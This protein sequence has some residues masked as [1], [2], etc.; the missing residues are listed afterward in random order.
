MFI[1]TTLFIF[2]SIAGMTFAKK[3]PKFPHIH[4]FIPRGAL[5]IV[6]MV[7]V[8]F[9]FANWVQGLFSNPQTFLK[10]SFVVLTFPG[11]FFAILGWIAKSPEVDWRESKKGRIAYRVLGIVV[12]LLVVQ[13][14]RGVN[15]T[16]WL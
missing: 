8:G 1:G 16:T 11:L 7:F 9:I 10:W 6:A 12:F 13:I 15:L 14:V 2:P 5:K 3:L 4:R